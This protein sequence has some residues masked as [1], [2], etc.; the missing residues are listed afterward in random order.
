MKKI[1]FTINKVRFIP[2]ML[3]QS[4]WADWLYICDVRGDRNFGKIKIEVMNHVEQ[5]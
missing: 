4:E 2:K 1:R 5:S 3:F